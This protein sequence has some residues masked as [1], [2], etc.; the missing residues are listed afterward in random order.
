M[1]CDVSGVGL[2][3][4]TGIVTKLVYHR[5][6]KKD[7]GGLIERDAAFVVSSPCS[8][9]RE[10]RKEAWSTEKREKKIKQKKTFGLGFKDSLTRITRAEEY[11]YK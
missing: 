6:E 10:E 1:I 8:E 11:S 7:K 3:E 5:F 9:K 2:F 4:P